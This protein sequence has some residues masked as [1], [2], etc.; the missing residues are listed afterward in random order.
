MTKEDLIKT[1][2]KEIH[3]LA[4]ETLRKNTQASKELKNPK[5]IKPKGLSEEELEHTLFYGGEKP[6]PKRVGLPQQIKEDYNNGVP[7]IN[8]SDV[9][10]FE[11][12]FENMLQEVE[13]ASVVFDKQSNGY[14]LKMWFGENGIEAGASGV[15]NLGNKG[16]IVWSYS[17]ANGLNVKV[18]SLDLEKGNKLVFEK[19]FNNY[20]DWQKDW[21]EK[22]TITPGQ[23]EP[24][25]N[26]DIAPM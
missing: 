2:R 7:K 15:I 20:N 22:L 4:M 3:E 12:S 25:Q 18:D 8:S 6:E 26:N 19:L 16:K 21:R 11:D 17:L 23:N 14:S 10:Q 5:V 1:I 24:P 9:T 13:G